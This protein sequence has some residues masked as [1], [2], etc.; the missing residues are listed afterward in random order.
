MRG[1]RLTERILGHPVT[2]HWGQQRSGQKS[3]A[4]ATLPPRG[5][6]WLG[7]LPLP[8]PV[9]VPCALPIFVT[10]SV[11]GS[12][13]HRQTC[14][15][16]HWEGLWVR[17]TTKPG[18]PHPAASS[19]RGSQSRQT[20]SPPPSSPW[21]PD[22]GTRPA[23]STLCSFPHFIPTAT[24]RGRSWVSP[25]RIWGQRIQKLIHG[26]QQVWLHSPALNFTPCPKAVK[27]RCPVEREAKMQ[28]KRT[29]IGLSQVLSLFYFIVLFLFCFVLLLVAP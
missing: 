9:P 13:S 10:T 1:L 7:A 16:N 18:S 23:W 17:D 6:P 12:G 29:P 20:V 2:R 21:V 14:N 25:F 24:T 3:L 8:G 26:T 27:D 5:T 22:G 15:A 28:V 19:R 4:S 11:S